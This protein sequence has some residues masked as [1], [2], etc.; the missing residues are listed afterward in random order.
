[1]NIEEHPC[2][3]RACSHQWTPTFVYKGYLFANYQSSTGICWGL[4]SSDDFLGRIDDCGGI[5]SLKGHFKP[6][7]APVINALAQLHR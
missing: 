4:Y 3:G 7:E 2:Y 1:M 6:E 5:R